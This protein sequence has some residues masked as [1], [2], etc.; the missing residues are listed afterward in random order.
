MLYE[1]NH[2]TG[3]RLK[4]GKGL[5]I[6]RSASSHVPCQEPEI[7]GCAKGSPT[8]GKELSDRNL[9]AVR[10]YKRCQAVNRWP[11]DATVARN[12]EVIRGIEDAVEA[13][14]REVTNSLIGS[15]R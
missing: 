7:L 6:L 1:Y 8:A 3:E 5:P 2:K 9:K 10:H 15:L 4:D 11:D 13:G 12:A 14:R